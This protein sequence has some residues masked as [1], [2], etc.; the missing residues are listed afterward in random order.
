[1]EVMEFFVK[2]LR[3]L[4]ASEMAVV[5]GGSDFQ[6]YHHRMVF[7]SP[8]WNASKRNGYRRDKRGLLN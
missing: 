6:D 2:S 1:M 5:V 4:M 7:K 3:G 8:E